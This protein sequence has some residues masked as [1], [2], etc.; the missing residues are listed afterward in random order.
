[1]RTIDKYLTESTIR[2][3][4]S[5]VKSL[6]SKKKS[7]VHD[8]G[9]IKVKMIIAGDTMIL[10]YPSNFY[11]LTYI[12]IDISDEMKYSYQQIGMN[13]KKDMKFIIDME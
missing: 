7:G 3:N 5:S 12:L 1:M 6:I 8:I 13:T 11:D 4:Q 2:L 9:G 10:E